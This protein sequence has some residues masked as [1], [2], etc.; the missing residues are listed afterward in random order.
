MLNEQVNGA[1]QDDVALSRNH[2]FIF[3]WLECYNVVEFY[4]IVLLSYH[5]HWIYM[6]MLYIISVYIYIYICVFQ[7]SHLSYCHTFMSS[8]ITAYVYIFLTVMLST[9]TLHVA[10]LNVLRIIF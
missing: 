3:E 6:M 5:A 8:C 1:D 2:D 7:C 9:G 10:L 4:P